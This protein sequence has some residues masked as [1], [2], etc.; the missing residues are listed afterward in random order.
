MLITSTDEI[1]IQQLGRVE[2][3]VTARL[4]ILSACP[5]VRLSVTR[6]L[7]DESKEPAGD[8]FIPH[9]MAVLVV[10]C[11][12]SYSYASADKISTHLRRR[13]VPLR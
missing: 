9:K 3:M 4:V 8:I 5:S 11:D 13:A 12:F 2:E 10:K 7:R 1:S 6:V